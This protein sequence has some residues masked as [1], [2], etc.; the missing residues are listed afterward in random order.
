VFGEAREQ[1]QR[2]WLAG[3]R[4][5][6]DAGRPFSRVRMVTEPLT[7]Y[8]R[9]ELATAPR[10]VEAGEIIRLIG[11]ARAHEL[12]LPSEDFW[13]FDDE[14]VAQMHFDDGGFTHADLID[15]AR[16]VGSFRGIRDL[17]WRNAVPFSEY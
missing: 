2:L 16:T 9:L 12:E 5:A 10:N 6:T 15:E 3:V 14:L 17:A 7:Y 8:L 13:L 1:G 11:A 4:A